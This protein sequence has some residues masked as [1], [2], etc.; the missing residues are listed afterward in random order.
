MKGIGWGLRAVT[1]AG[2]YLPVG[3]GCFRA[4]TGLCP[5][6]GVSLL[7]RTHPHVGTRPRPY[8]GL[9]DSGAEAPEGIRLCPYNCRIEVRLVAGVRF[10]CCGEVGRVDWGE[11]V[12]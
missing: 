4:E 8:I 12:C 1:G 2:I 6:I 7:G 9:R 10:S 3:F 11:G 5:Y